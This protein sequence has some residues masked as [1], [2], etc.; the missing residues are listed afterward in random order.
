M[1]EVQVFRSRLEDIVPAEELLFEPTPG[2]G[3]YAPWLKHA[4]AHPA[5]MNTWLL[6]YLVRAF[7]EPGGWVVVT[8]E[9]LKQLDKVVE[10]CECK[11]GEK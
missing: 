2:F 4:V 1:T 6:E 8:E 9:L 10:W 7:T 11:H 3:Y 5:K